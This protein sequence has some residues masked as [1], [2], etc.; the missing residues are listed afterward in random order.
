MA[1]ITLYDLDVE[2]VD[3]A[4]E[5]AEGDTDGWSYGAS[6]EAGKSFQTSE[7][8]L[9]IP[10][11]G[12]VWNEVDIDDYES[13]DGVERSF[14]TVQSTLGY[15][16]LRSDYRSPIVDSYFDAWLL[17]GTVKVEH[18]FDG[19]STAILVDPASGAQ[20]SSE[21]DGEDTR[22]GFIGRVAILQSDVKSAHSLGLTGGYTTSLERDSDAYN[23]SLEFKVSW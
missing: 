12:L 23:G 10:N 15:V 17:S 18:E 4:T 21:L 8:V 20:T 5:G 19:D 13:S 2:D 6:I 9:F 11:V 7:N 16:G 14:D 1:H 3:G 22:L